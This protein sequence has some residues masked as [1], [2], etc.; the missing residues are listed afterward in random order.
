MYFQKKVKCRINTNVKIMI[1][2]LFLKRGED[3]VHSIKMQIKTVILCEPDFH[4][5]KFL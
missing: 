3:K 4:C 1:L 5:I 2:L